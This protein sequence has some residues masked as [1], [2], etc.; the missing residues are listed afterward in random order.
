MAN[1]KLGICEWVMPIK[2]TLA[3]QI[4]AE[5]GLDGIQID[6]LGGY[7]AC[8]PLANKR[9]QRGYL[10]ASQQY[11]VELAS[12]GANSFAKGGGLVNTPG[13]PEWEI[14]RLGLEVNIDACAAMGIPV[15]MLP[16]FW[17]GYIFTDEH[18]ENCVNMLK[19][20]CQ[21]AAEKN[22]TLALESVLPAEKLV[23][24]L[25]LPGY[26][27]LKVY[28]DTENSWHFADASPS[29][30]LRIL[31]KDRIAQIHLKDGTKE[32]QGFKILGE[33]DTGVLMSMETIKEIGFDGY[34]IL[35]NFYNKPPMLPNIGMDALEL[36]KKDI[37]VI[38]SVFERA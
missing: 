6:D 33:G 17:R 36:I 38:K 26:E 9:I 13:T 35:E 24:L 21:M 4:A 16:C 27:N 30:E 34:L 11:G 7:R 5:L 10:E 28:Y 14:S 19:L 31:G 29:E 8:F 20:A 22:I 3:V 18:F 32:T 15:L 37:A 2:G 12:L 25:A 23:Q 1:N